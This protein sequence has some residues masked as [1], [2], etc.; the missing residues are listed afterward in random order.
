[1]V[2]FNDPEEDEELK[3]P[4]PP[5]S[6]A[7]LRQLEL[8]LAF[9]HVDFAEEYLQQRLC[10][11]I[12]DQLGRLSSLEELTLRS[13]VTKSLKFLSRLRGLKKLR[14]VFEK[15]PWWEELS[16]DPWCKWFRLHA[17]EVV[18]NEFKGF[19]T[20]PS[21]S[22]EVWQDRDADFIYLF[23]DDESEVLSEI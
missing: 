19:T 4:F 23:S 21:I 16:R 12:L 14:W 18:E 7:N 17:K 3:D 13:K 6:L 10:D 11:R 22:I 8:E 20:R 1:M 15:H 2:S 5:A 9:T